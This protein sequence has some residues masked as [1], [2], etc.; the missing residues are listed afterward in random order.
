MR[1]PAAVALRRELDARHPRV[2]AI[3]YLD[4][5]VPDPTLPQ[6]IEWIVIG[7]PSAVSLAAA[8]IG[9]RR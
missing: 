2:A 7:A 9:L 6:L 1:V 4:V 5:Y 3:E 8:V